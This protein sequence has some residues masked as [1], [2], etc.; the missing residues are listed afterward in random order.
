MKHLPLQR[1]F[2]G[3][4]MAGSLWAAPSFAQDRPT[5]AIVAT[6]GTIASKVDPITHAPV[7]AV[8]GEDLIAAVPHLSN[9]ALAGQRM[10]AVIPCFDVI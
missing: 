5:V 1:A 2:L 7:P 10:R 6:G 4:I 9:S 3:L 8:S